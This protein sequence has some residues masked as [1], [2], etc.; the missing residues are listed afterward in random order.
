MPPRQSGRLTAKLQLAL[1]QSAQT[2]QVASTNTAPV[3][4]LTRAQT[5]PR[6]KQKVAGKAEAKPAAAP[7]PVQDDFRKVKGRRGALKTMTEMPVDILLEIFRQVEPVDLLHLSWATKDL[8]AM[9]MDSNAAFLWPQVYRNVSGKKPPPCPPGMNFAH[10]TNLLYGK[11]CNFC[12]SNRG[13]LI[14]WT[15]R[16]RFCHKCAPEQLV[17]YTYTGATTTSKDPNI[18]NICPLWFFSKTDSLVRGSYLLKAEHDHHE[19]KLKE[20]RN[21]KGKVDY[22]KAASK[23][24]TERVRLA[25]ALYAWQR[26]RKSEDNSARQARITSRRNA[27][28]RRVKEE[29]YEQ[30]LNRYG[31][32]RLPGVNVPTE[33]TDKI[34]ERIKPGIIELLEIERQN[35]R[36]DGFKQRFRTRINRIVDVVMSWADKQPQPSIIP[37]YV[38]F[39]KSETFCD[40]LRDL[41]LTETQL[42]E[43]VDELASQ[44]PAISAAW[45]S[46][47]DEI[48]RD[49]LRGKGDPKS[50]STSV[51]PLGLAVTFFKCRWCN[52]PINYPRILMHSCLRHRLL[53]PAE[54]EDDEDKVDEEEEG[55][56][57]VDDDDDDGDDDSTPEPANI[58]VPATP[59]GVWDELSFWYSS[60]WNEGN[61]DVFVDEEASGFAA[62]IVKACGEDPQTTTFSRMEEIDARLECVRCSDSLTSKAKKRLVMNWKMAILHDIEVH[63]ENPPAEQ[64]WSLLTD[65]A[66]LA[67]V[68]QAEAKMMGKWKIPD[69]MCTRCK[70]PVPAKKVEDHMN[71]RHSSR[72][73][74]QIDVG[75]PEVVYKGDIYVPLDL[76]MKVPPYA[77]KI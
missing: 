23:Q 16:A 35:R 14:H 26:N 55:A 68:K 20:I 64:G 40:V 63:Y 36:E 62:A 32:F 41:S 74:P 25:H 17:L 73:G 10:Y 22:E 75:P 31:Q 69:Y 3:P 6:K 72:R 49:L 12:A 4:T 67:K 19:K 54:K 77:V 9:I 8:R 46:E 30:E 39:A 15:A 5:R 70:Y 1:E 43:R 29:G 59:E 28:V 58:V 13:K 71:Y 7:A 34:W 50:S 51:D 47:A 53:K 33:L 57:G 65:E 48:L 2:S 76:P 38:H 27:I 45:K 61:N 11:H 52:D 44:I 21:N 56:E 60:T 37:P 42:Q 24:K 18:L 66:D